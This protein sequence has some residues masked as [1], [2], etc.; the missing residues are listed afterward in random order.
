MLSFAKKLEA[1]SGIPAISRN[2]LI[3]S[4]PLLC[5]VFDLQWAAKVLR[6]AAEKCFF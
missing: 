3:G 2:L 6:A 5:L 4:L 1:G